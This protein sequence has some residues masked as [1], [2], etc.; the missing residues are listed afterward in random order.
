MYVFTPYY[1]KCFFF[2]LTF[3]LRLPTALLSRPSSSIQCLS[4][5]MSHFIDLI[6]LSTLPSSLSNSYPSNHHNSL[7]SPT[8][9]SQLFGAKLDVALSIGNKH[10]RGAA[11]AA[12]EA[13]LTKR[14]CVELPPALIKADKVTILFSVS[15]LF[16]LY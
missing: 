10:K 9:F 7:S 12:V 6:S 3:H 4:I 16:M 2:I 13:E 8:F 15:V 14:F 11:V 5:G 1:S